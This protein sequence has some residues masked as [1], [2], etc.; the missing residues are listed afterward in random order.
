MSKKPFP[1]NVIIFKFRKAEIY[2]GGVFAILIFALLALIFAAF[3][4]RYFGIW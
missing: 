4:S 1:N 3:A 2:L